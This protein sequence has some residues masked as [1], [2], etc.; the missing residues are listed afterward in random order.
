MAYKSIPFY[1]TNRG[2][3]IFVDHT[4]NVSFEVASEKV[5]YVGFSVPGEEIRY[6][7]IYG[8]SNQEVLSRYTAL[9]GR[10]APDL[11]GNIKL[12]ATALRDGNKIVLSATRLSPGMSF[13]LHDIQDV[14]AIQGA[15][16]DIRGGKVKIIP[17]E[18]EV[19]VILQ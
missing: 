18:K 12:R 6:Y 15:T 3:G 4:D 9:T 17:A 16:Y 13:V 7:F 8:D 2:Y 19:Q 10:P 14:K 11:D 5:E 1:M